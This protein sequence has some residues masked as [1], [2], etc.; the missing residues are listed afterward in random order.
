MSVGTKE[1]PV[2]PW[3]KDITIWINTLLPREKV[4]V[5]ILAIDWDEHYLRN[6]QRASFSWCLLAIKGNLFVAKKCFIGFSISLPFL[7]GS[8]SKKENLI[9]HFFNNWLVNTTSTVKLFN[10]T[11]RY[12]YCKVNKR[13]LFLP[14]SFN[15]SIMSF[16]AS[17][18]WH[19]F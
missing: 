18:N 6:K 7:I 12:E 4:R 13:N 10:E 1:C 3:F 17:L 11:L 2:A 15:G 16:D 19:S 9:T 8:V 5:W 14:E